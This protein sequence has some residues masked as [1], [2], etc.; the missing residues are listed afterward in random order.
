[1]GDPLG[2]GPLYAEGNRPPQWGTPC[3]L[4]L[5][6]GQI[7]AVLAPDLVLVES[8]VALAEELH[9]GAPQNGSAL[10]RRFS[11]SGSLASS[12]SSA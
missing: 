9:F 4:G 5:E 1:M 10:H 2:C 6:E 7:V 8:F 12:A 3:R 11:I